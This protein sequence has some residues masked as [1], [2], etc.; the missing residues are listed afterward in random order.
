V[1]VIASLSYRTVCL[2]AT[3]E[4]QTDRSVCQSTSTEGAAAEL[5]VGRAGSPQRNPLG[6]VVA[7]VAFSRLPPAITE[8]ADDPDAW[9]TR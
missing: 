5:P 4:Y 6:E 7:D 8:L 3:K 2:S 1:A 9:V